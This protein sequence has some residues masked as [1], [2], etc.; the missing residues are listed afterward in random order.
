MNNER[1]FE[2]VNNADKE[3]NRVLLI[4]DV[5]KSYRISVECSFP[6]DDGS[7]LHNAPCPQNVTQ[8]IVDFEITILHLVVISTFFRY[9][10]YRL[11][12]FT[13]PKV[14]CSEWKRYVGF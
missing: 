11:I 8:T 12:F 6:K 9:R 14:A 4:K 3:K 7:Y 10:E 5:K 13:F 1:F 2:N